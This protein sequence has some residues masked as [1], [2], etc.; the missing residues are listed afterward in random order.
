MAELAIIFAQTVPVKKTRGMAAFLVERSMPGWSSHDIR[1]K[2]GLRASSTAE[3]ILDGV[4]VPD[5]NVLGGIGQGF[6]VAMSAL[7]D[8]RY[9]VAA[10]C[11]GIMQGCLDA[12]VKYVQERQAFG[13]K[14]GEF[15]L[16]QELIA[17]MR[18]DLEA[19][20]LL[21]WRAGWLKDQGS[22]GGVESSLVSISVGLNISG[23]WNGDLYSYLSYDNQLV[24]LLNRPGRT[25]N[26]A[27]GYSDSGFNITLGA[28]GADI[29]MYQT[30]ANYSTAIV[31]PGYA[32]AADG[33]N[34]DPLTVTDNADRNTSLVNFNGMNPNGN[35]TLFLADL[36][37]GG[38]SRLDSWSLNIEAVPEPAP[39]FARP[40]AP[41]AAPAKK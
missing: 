17:E 16:V 3:L 39:Y 25:A 41:A 9:S 4:R 7:D 35:W 10:G 37:G 18:L 8:G 40:A 14:I 34:T 12:S 15:Q 23:G 13:K 31:T 1:G 21:V 2:L 28:S 32:W 26:N 29:H 22:P 33:R 19:A 6:K 36:S 11:V 38:I 30:V 20:R 27:F 5:E 24:V